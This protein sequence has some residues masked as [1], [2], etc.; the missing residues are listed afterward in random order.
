[1]RSE[2]V[3]GWA[4]AAL[5][6]G[7]G[8]CGP[9]PFRCDRHG[10]ASACS[11]AGAVC[12]R[13]GL[14]ATSVSAG[15]CASGLR[16]TDTAA[17]PRACVGVEQ[18]PSGDAGAD[19]ASDAGTGAVDSGADIGARDTGSV[20]L[21]TGA[22]TDAGFRCGPLPRMIGPL[23]GYLASSST[24]PAGFEFS[25][26]GVGDITFEFSPARDFSRG[27]LTAR[28]LGLGIAFA[29]SLS[30]GVWWWRVRR[31]CT[32][33]GAMV[34]D[35]APTPFWFTVQRES[36]RPMRLGHENT[37]WQ[38]TLDVDG[39]SFADLAVGDP[40]ARRVL[41]Y[42]GSSTGLPTSPSA[43]L[44]GESGFGSAVASPGDMDG[45]GYGDLAVGSCAS[46]ALSCSA[47]LRVY[48]GSP[49]GVS[50][51]AGRRYEIPSPGQSEAPMFGVTLS[52]L[53]DFDLDGYADLAVGSSPA[54]RYAPV[55]VYRGAAS[56]FH[57]RATEVRGTGSPDGFGR[58][59]SSAGD[60]DGDKGGDLVVGDATGRRLSL[61]RWVRPLIGAGRV[62]VYA[63]DGAITGMASPPNRMLGAAVALI[64]DA[65]DDGRADLVAAAPESQSLYVVYGVAE[66]S[67]MDPPRLV[68][69]PQLDGNSLVALFGA[70]DVDSDGGG[71]FALGYSGANGGGRRVVLYRSR[72][73]GGFA[74][75]VLLELPSNTGDGYTPAVTGGD[76]NGDLFDDVAATIWSLRSDQGEARVG[77]V[78]NGGTH[79]EGVIGVNPRS[80]TTMLTPPMGSSPVFGR[81]LR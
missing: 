53:G 80:P 60:F 32:V 41:V 36:S 9:S 39:D 79:F 43:V 46:T 29:P 67:R 61:A 81:T 25:L 52:G 65:N 27:L 2:S 59:M 68:V 70:L 26:T 34:S 12:T 7:V 11:G 54:G 69:N 73:G 51:D 62:D 37:G 49:Q 55:L 74:S 21:D 3:V 14:C 10:G 16:Y 64:G 77:S 42:Y 1:M 47:P 33:A 71:D 50:G 75:E 35:V 38:A 8:G 19:D 66:P 57:L 23:S 28:H 30:P 63:Y 5:F 4:L 17:R 40:D 48:R 31:H 15:E 13:E 45:D 20:T 44:T 76:Y 56:G 22:V 78:Y 58:V 18:R 6:A 24:P 72:A